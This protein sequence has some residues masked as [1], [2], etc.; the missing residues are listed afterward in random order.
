MHI[1]LI[2]IIGVLL[3]V[4]IAWYLL[5]QLSLPPPVRMV[6]IVVACVIL[7]LIVADMFGVFSLGGRV[8]LT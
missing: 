4:A 3:I 1:A 2:P 5:N 6:V 7:I 8:S